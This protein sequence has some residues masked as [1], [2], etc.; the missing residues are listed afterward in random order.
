MS[1]SMKKL[2]LLNQLVLA[3][4]LCVQASAQS[5]AVATEHYAKEGLSFD[6]PKGWTLTD[7]SNATAQEIVLTVPGTSVVI[8]VVAFRELLQNAGQVRATRDSVTM[9]HAMN[10]ASRF[11]SPL[12]QLSDSADCLPVGQRLASGFKLIGQLDKQPITGYVYSIVLGQRFLNFTYIRVDKDDARGA[13]GWKMLLDTLKVEP[14]AGQTLDAAKLDEIVTGGVLNGKSIKKPQPE[15]PAVAKSA[16]AQG[17]VS[18]QITVDENGDVIEAHA[19]SGHPLLRGA[20]EQAARR[21][22]FAPTKLCGKPVKVRGIIT[23]GFVL[24]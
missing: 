5:V 22:K 3:L 18:V 21:A 19:V 24:R 16:R 23:Y 17:T 9:R 4:L 12:S 11:G 8:Q 13:E 14:P 2:L 10:L 6:Y 1:T 7:K 20:G 15:Y